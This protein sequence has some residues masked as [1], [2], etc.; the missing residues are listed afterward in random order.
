M[1]SNPS[2]RN[3]AHTKSARPN[4]PDDLTVTELGTWMTYAEVYELLGETRDTV[5]KWRKRPEVRFP[6]GVRKPNGKLMFR[7]SDIA[8]FI[9]T[10]E[11]AA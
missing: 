9:G 10:L 6:S 1:T 4:N 5:N 7:R 3:G 8:A 11:V 2:R